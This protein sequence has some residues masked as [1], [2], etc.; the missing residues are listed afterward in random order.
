M[1]TANILDP[2]HG[3]LEPRVWDNPVDPKPK[4]KEQHRKWILSTIHGALKGAGYTDSEKWLSLVLTGS[5]TTYQYSDQSDVDVSLWVDAEVFPEWSRAE[6]IGVMVEK[7]DG[8][9]LPGTPHPLQGFVVAKGMN[10]DKLYQPGLRS[11]YD[12]DQAVWIVPPERDRTHD[13]QKEESGFY[14]YAVECAD[15]MERL[16]RYEPDKAVQYWHMIH[17]RRME[18]QKQG[19]GDY[20][21]SNII[22]KFLANRG[23]MPLIAD[24][25][26][27]YIA[28]VGAEGETCTSCGFPLQP[29]GIGGEA[30]CPHCGTEYGA[31]EPEK[32]LFQE[33]EEVSFHDPGNVYHDMRLR[34]RKPDAHYPGAH[35]VSPVD[36]QQTYPN[37]VTTDNLRRIQGDSDPTWHEFWHG[38]KT[39]GWPTVA[40]F[41]Y[42]VVNNKLVFGRMAPEEGATES[43]YDLLH[44]GGIDTANAAFGQVRED[45]MGEVF[46]RPRITGPGSQ[47]N[48]YEVDYRTEEAVR[49]VLPGVRFYQER[50]LLNPD[51]ELEADPQV[52]YAGEP[53]RINA[54]DSAQQSPVEAWSFN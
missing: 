31:P 10:K 54:N 36:S 43:H 37:W 20:S 26:G 35:W 8:V 42:D 23:L 3:E 50:E 2:I 25:S 30:R 6:M 13:V 44:L 40:K 29:L 21:E 51:W 49:R 22:Y 16:L 9:K 18:D 41:V 52:V 28:K 34:Y 24:V 48:P 46:G 12:L 5:L 19:K 14:V 27:E 11:G 1:Y 7:L 17:K 47:L 39:A 4:L 38:G 32:P 15:K 45:G 53:P 33:G